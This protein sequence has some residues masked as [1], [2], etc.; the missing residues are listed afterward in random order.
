MAYDYKQHWH[1]ISNYLPLGRSY[2]A[3][4]STNRPLCTGY[5]LPIEYFR[6]EITLS[7]ET[8]P[9]SLPEIG[10][11]LRGPCHCSQVARSSWAIFVIVVGIIRVPRLYLWDRRK[12]SLLVISRLWRD[13]GLRNVMINFDRYWNALLADACRVLNGLSRY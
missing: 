9:L 8:I 7:V 11:L 5:Y 6:P 3:I 4:L 13:A 2:S 1:V 10:F 12:C